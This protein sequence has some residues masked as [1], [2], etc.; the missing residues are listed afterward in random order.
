MTDDELDAAIMTHCVRERRKV[1]FIVMLTFGDIPRPGPQ[2][3]DDVYIARRVKAL[4]AK[5]RLHAWGDPQQMRF[6]EVSLPD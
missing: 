1:A 3:I 4:V 5:G 6:S 2:H